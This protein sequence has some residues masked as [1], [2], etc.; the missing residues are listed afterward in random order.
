MTQVNLQ[1]M[2]NKALNFTEPVKSLILSEA[3][4][5]DAQEFIAKLGTWEKLI[6]MEVKEK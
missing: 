2:K 4:N 1:P 6:R 3:D 5:L